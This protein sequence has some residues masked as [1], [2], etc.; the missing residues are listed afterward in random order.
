MKVQDFINISTF[1]EYIVVN[2]KGCSASD[3]I[4]K[5]DTLIEYGLFELVEVSNTIK[6]H[7][8]KLDVI[9][10]LKIK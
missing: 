2:D 5:S 1:E 7:N 4:D 10:V 8:S 9:C 3:I 6:L